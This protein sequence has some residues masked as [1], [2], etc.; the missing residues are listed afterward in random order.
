VRLPSAKG[1]VT[2]RVGARDLLGNSVSQTIDRAV[3]L[4]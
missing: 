2:L 3:G 1:E 4:R